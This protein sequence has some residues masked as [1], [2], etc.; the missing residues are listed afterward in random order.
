MIEA[1]LDEGH[2]EER[3]RVLA[4]FV[5]AAL[6]HA[7]ILV[8][9]AFCLGGGAPVLPPVT[10]ELQ[11]SSGP[12]MDGWAAS[13]GSSG[14]LA[15]GEGTE[16]AGPAAPHS[17]AR[18]PVSRSQG[19][20][21]GGFVIPTPRVQPSDSTGPS[22]SGPAFREVGGRTGAVQAVP[23]VP[24]PV[25]APSVAP[26]QR[27][28]G[29]G[30]AATSGGGASP[31]QRS[32][33]GVLVNGTSGSVSGGSLDLSQLDRALSGGSSAKG[34]GGSGGAGN[35]VGA[36]GSGGAGAG[37]GPGYSVRW[38]GGG[39]GN[40][41]T[42]LSTS[43]P[44]LPLWVNKQGLTLSVTVSFTVLADGAIGGVSLQQSCG[45]ADVDAAVVDA[46]RRW[47]FTPAE[48]AAPAKGLIP[49]IIRPQ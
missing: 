6:V 12:G 39:S 37:G 48:G 45:Y 41:R 13:A 3:K 22:T 7:L 24:T 9:L 44:K 38:G 4:S 43:P 49:Y 36:A 33:T 27:G 19:T 46:V 35:G 26:A 11:V 25:P 29:G 14:G 34:G 21:A 10:I 20:N 1:T 23:S 16:L 32:G 5:A 31:A 17:T 47:R 2:V 40:G 30:S 15:A 28:M 18:A 42:L 8:A